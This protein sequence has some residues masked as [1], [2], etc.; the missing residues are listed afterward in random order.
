MGAPTNTY[1]SGADLSLGHVPETIEDEATYKELLDIHNAIE[2]LLT[3]VETN[4]ANDRAFIL[5]TGD[6]TVL[7]T[8]RLI[9]VDATAA[10]VTITMYP[11]ADGIGLTHEIK[12]IAGD[13]ETLIIGD[14]V[15]V[16]NSVGAIDSDLAGIIIDLLE[17]IPLKND[18]SNW[19]I[20]N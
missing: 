17:A 4:L 5:V 3:Y 8:D 16:S 18:G 2:I 19:W 13:N 12:Q 14:P 1:N 9:L 11:T 20:H 6:Y 10:D 7:T 15:D